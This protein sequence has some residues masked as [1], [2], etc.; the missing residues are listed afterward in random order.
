METIDLLFFLLGAIGL[1]T[2][3]LKSL[4][5][6]RNE[7]RVTKYALNAASNTHGGKF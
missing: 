4:Q 7:W 2:L 3:V 1:I 6:Y 5:I